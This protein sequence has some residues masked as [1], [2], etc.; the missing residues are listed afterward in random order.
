MTLLN[1]RFH[2]HSTNTEVPVIIAGLSPMRLIAIIS[3]RK[4]AS[5]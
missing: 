3:L 2:D 4:H 5:K 1:A